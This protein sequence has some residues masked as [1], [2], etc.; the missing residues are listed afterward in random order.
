MLLQLENWIGT[1]STYC[2]RLSLSSNIAGKTVVFSAL[3]NDDHSL[4]GGGYVFSTNNTGQWVNASWV[5]FSST[6]CWGNATLTLNNKAGVVVGFREY[7]NNSL[8]VWAD[9]GLYT[10]ITTNESSDLYLL[11]RQLPHQPQI[12]HQ[13]HRCT[14]ISNRYFIFHRKLQL[15]HLPHTHTRQFV[16][17]TNNSDSGFSC[18]RVGCFVGCGFQERLHNHRSSG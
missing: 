6:P 5:A 18:R 1:E 10:I 8:N 9:S 7:A 12:Q 4:S 2:F 11:L 15:R 14:F 3:W 17:H 13:L 16:F